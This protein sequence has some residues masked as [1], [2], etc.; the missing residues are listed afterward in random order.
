MPSKRNCFR[1]VWTL[2]MEIQFLSTIINNENRKYYFF[3][4]S[5]ILIEDD[6][7]VLRKNWEILIKIS[8]HSHA[9]LMGKIEDDD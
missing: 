6:F 2:Y 4:W 5:S 1:K 9:T 7:D 3:S 8:I